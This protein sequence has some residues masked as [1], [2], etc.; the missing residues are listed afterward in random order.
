MTVRTKA[1]L[2]AI[3][4]LGTM[5]ITGCETIKGIAQGAQE[6]AK[7]DWHALMRTDDKMREVLW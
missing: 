4:I 1:L 6:G 5:L 3:S 2:L 7:K